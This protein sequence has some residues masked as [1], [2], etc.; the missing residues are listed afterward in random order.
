MT[1]PTIEPAMAALEALHRARTANANLGYRAEQA[2][3][4]EACID[5]QIAAV[6]NGRFTTEE[7][8][9]L[10]SFNDYVVAQFERMDE[11]GEG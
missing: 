9:E 11:E 10:A 6:E 2:S 3:V 7:L 8:I 1:A 5:R 4:V